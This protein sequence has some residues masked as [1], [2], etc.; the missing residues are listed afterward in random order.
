METGIKLGPVLIRVLQVSGQE[1][2]LRKWIHQFERIASI[3]FYA[4]LS[5][6]DKRVAG[7]GE[8]VCLLLMLT[9]YSPR[10]C[11]HD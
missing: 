11:R 10:G 5:D 2:A 3:L 9:T 7:W 4:P 6:Y 8:Q 1:S